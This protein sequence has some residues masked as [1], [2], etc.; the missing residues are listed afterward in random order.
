MIIVI[1]G[2]LLFFIAGAF[3]V[4]GFFQAVKNRTKQA[5]IYFAIGFLCIGIFIVVLFMY[6]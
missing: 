4:V 1:L 5:F 2:I 3:A 6:M